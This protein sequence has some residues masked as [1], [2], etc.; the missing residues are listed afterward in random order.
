MNPTTLDQV[1]PE[2]LRAYV[3]QRV[4][5]GAYADTAEYLRDLVRRDRDEQ[6]AK[7]LRQLVE[8][9]LVSGPATPL[10]EAEIADIRARVA[11][12]VR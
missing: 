7:R 11:S 12:F 2:P 1:L 8:E 3:E 4:R 9:G 5:E 10:T 6:A